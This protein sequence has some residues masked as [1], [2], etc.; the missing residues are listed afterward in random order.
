MARATFPKGSLAIR[1]RDVLGPLF[2]EEE[3]AD[4]FATRGKPAWSPGR[5]APVSVVQFVEG[6]TNRQA[7]EAVRAKIDSTD[8]LTAARDVCWL[9]RCRRHYGRR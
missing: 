2:C 5:L 6:L 8:V 7:S 4:L 3:C 1:V 9:E